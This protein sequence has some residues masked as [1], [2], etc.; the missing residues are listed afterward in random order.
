MIKR[1][2]KLYI[3]GIGPGGSDD[4]TARARR[5]I[6]ASRVVVGYSRYIERIAPLCRGKIVVASGMGKEV[7]RCAAA[8]REAL[9]GKKVALVSGG[10]AGIYGMAGLVLEM[11]LHKGI[12]DRRA[13]EIIPGVPAFAA[14]AA[15]CGAPLMN[16][17]AVVSLSDLLTPWTRIA[18]RLTAAAQGDFVVCLYNPQSS[19]RTTQLSRARS[20]FMK[21]RSGATPCAVLRHVAGQDES[22]K[23]TTLQDLLKHRIDMHS[24]VIIGNSQTR[25]DGAWLITGRGYKF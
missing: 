9:M 10:D 15:R 1:S 13:I 11:A 25:A 21:Y 19:R 6:A 3:V 22:V 7:E 23:I 2:G 14:G 18:K 16:D 20:I 8:L 5:A 12:S 4:M 24:M 17:F